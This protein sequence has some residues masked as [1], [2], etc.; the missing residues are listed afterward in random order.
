MNPYLL[1]ILDMLFYRPE[2]DCARCDLLP[3]LCPV[4]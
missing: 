1:N 2:G 4:L 3:R